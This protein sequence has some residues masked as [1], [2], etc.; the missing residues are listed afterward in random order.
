MEN[1]YLNRATEFRDIFEEML[2]Y[3]EYYNEK[4]NLKIENI[5]NY[6]YQE[7]FNNALRY[8]VNNK[9]IQ[10]YTTASQDSLDKYIHKA[11]LEDKEVYKNNTNSVEEIYIDSYYSGSI[12]LYNQIYRLCYGSEDEVLSEL[13]ER[14]SLLKDK[15]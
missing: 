10:A 14:R 9:D 12:A 7:G 1:R 4:S 13:E 6:Y 8:I 11:A 3:E 2:K 5:F 15:V